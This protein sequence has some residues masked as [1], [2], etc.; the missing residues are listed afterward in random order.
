LNRKKSVQK[1]QIGN[2]REAISWE[3][4]VGNSSNNNNNDNNIT[5]ATNK[6]SNKLDFSQGQDIPLDSI[7]YNSVTVFVWTAWRAIRNC[8]FMCETT[9]PSLKLLFLLERESNF[10]FTTNAFTTDLISVTSK[11]L[12]YFRMPCLLY[13]RAR[14][15]V[16]LYVSDSS[17][18]HHH[19]LPRHA[20]QVSRECLAHVQSPSEV[21]A[22]ILKCYYS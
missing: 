5:A 4:R 18:T 20:Y 14:S 13:L 9:F 6:S 7:N 19:T 3:R 16:G 17:L 22:P 21:R 1:E 8:R 15:L 11:R 2:K 10:T 12:M